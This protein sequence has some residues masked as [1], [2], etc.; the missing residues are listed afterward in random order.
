MA[1]KH[2][3]RHDLAE[4]AEATTNDPTRIWWATIKT[5]HE[6]SGL[7]PRLIDELARTGVIRSSH[8]RRP[9]ATRGRRLIDMNSLFTYIEAGVN[10][11]PAKLVMNHPA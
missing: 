9:G 10:Q 7:S 5:A 3:T 11:P 4:T 2:H 6:R 8:A 1:S